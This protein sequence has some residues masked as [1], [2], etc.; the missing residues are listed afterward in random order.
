[1]NFGSVGMIR[2][3]DL[4]PRCL[5]AASPPF[6]AEVAFSS[7]LPCQLRLVVA[8][9]IFEFKVCLAAFNAIMPFFIDPPLLNSANPWATTIDDLRALYDCE[10][11]GAVTTRTCTLEGFAH[12]DAIHQ[13]TFF[14]LQTLQSSPN[15]N[16]SEERT[17]SLNTL[18]YSPISLPKLV[19][20]LVGFSEE[21]RKR[22]SDPTNTKVARKDKPFIISITGTPQELK[23]C[24][25]VI[26]SKYLTLRNEFP[27]YIEINLS[28]PN[29]S[30]T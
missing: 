2:L 29:I 11:T 8:G 5:P 3:S 12:D 9:A 26:K 25:T 18:G 7:L 15:P 24:Y 19:D 22:H 1:M 21:L 16:Q 28:C 13:Y 6:I 17:G 14:D 4:V 23:Q 30:G 20:L 27:V 10:Y